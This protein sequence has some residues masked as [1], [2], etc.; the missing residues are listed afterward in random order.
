MIAI[1]AARENKFW[2]LNDFLYHYNMN[3]GT[4]DL[5]QIS[6]KTNL[7]FVTLKTGIHER[8]TKRKL[9]KDILSGLKRHI[10]ATPSYVINEKVYTGQIQPDILNSIKK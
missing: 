5:Q 6:Q 4:I 2:E 7:D 3:K 10:T 8:E 9:Q 1:Y